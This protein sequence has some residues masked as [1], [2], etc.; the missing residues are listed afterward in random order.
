[1]D[2]LKTTKHPVP[3]S[4]TEGPCH[5]PDTVIVTWDGPDDPQDPFNWPLQKKWWATGLGLVASFVC[6]MN[7][8]IIAVFPQGH[9]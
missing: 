4:P 9:Q 6:S 2:E 3:G 8:T 5:E 7:G 1:M